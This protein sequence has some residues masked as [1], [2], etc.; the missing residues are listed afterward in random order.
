MLWGAP[1]SL[2]LALGLLVRSIGDGRAWKAMK[3]AWKDYRVARIFKNK[4]RMTEEAFRIRT[5][6]ESIGVTVSAFEEL[7]LAWPIG[8]DGETK[9]EGSKKDQ[10]EAA[11]DLKLS[12]AV[13]S[14]TI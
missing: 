2:L 13:N 10:R 6:Q 11:T 14:I 5:I 12:Q 4:D 8:L 7:D 3:W 1:F 9:L